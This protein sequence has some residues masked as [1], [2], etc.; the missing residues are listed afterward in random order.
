MADKPVE[1]PL[2]V[3]KNIGFSAWGLAFA[4]P[5]VF[6]YSL[7]DILGPSGPLSARLWGFA[8]PLALL[9]VLIV[10][11]LVRRNPC[12][13]TIDLSGVTYVSRRAPLF[14]A[15]SDVD[16]VTTLDKTV[17]VELKGR[18]EDEGVQIPGAL[19][20]TPA[21]LAE[22]LRAG[23]ERWGGSSSSRVRSE[24]PA[25]AG[26]ALTVRTLRRTLVGLCATAGAAGI[27]MISVIAIPA[28]KDSQL[29][30]H[31]V[32]AQAMVERIYTGDCGRSGCSRK[33]QYAYHAPDGRTLHGVGDLG[34]ERDSDDP[35]YVYAK[36]HPTVP[37]VLDP[38]N[39]A[40]SD[41]NI[42]DNVFTTDHVGRALI[43]LGLLG[44]TM[45]GIFAL[46]GIPLFRA[47]RKAEREV[48]GEA[49]VA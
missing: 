16:R 25:G 48:A 11:Y 20:K 49:R 6:L 44:V 39:P 22:A 14:I 27:L 41:L 47:L 30:A 35:D 8:T 2:R 33:L 23:L 1:L 45:A 21:K 31:G 26:R 9:G 3:R 17:R 37:I 43:V 29:K 42:G 24:L 4:S 7:G 13:L 46:I 18:P 28:V 32:R 12:E 38:A 15:W 10:V 40:L 36:T 19:L 34:A 5:F